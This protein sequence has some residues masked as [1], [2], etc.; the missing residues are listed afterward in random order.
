MEALPQLWQALN[1]I[2]LNHV[3]RQQKNGKGNTIKIIQ[4]LGLYFAQKKERQTNEAIVNVLDSFCNIFCNNHRRICAQ[5]CSLVIYGCILYFFTFWQIEMKAY[6]LQM[7][8]KE[9]LKQPALPPSHKPMEAPPLKI[10]ANRR[11][12]YAKLA[13]ARESIK[14]IG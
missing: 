14:S 10:D 4:I 11:E 12:L 8:T 2:R 9:L 13:A 7:N 3:K 6:D 1:L 5:I